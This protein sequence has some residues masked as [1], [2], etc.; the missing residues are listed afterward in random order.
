MMNEIRDFGACLYSLGPKLFA[1]PVGNP[2]TPPP[3]D[4]YRMYCSSCGGSRR[5]RVEPVFWAAGRQICQHDAH[6]EYYYWSARDNVVI[7]HPDNLISITPGIFRLR[8]TDCDAESLAVL[9]P[10][11][12]GPNGV[13]LAVLPARWAG[14]ATPNTPAAV[15]Y[16]LD[17]AARCI[18]VDA[19]SAAIAMFRSALEQFL[20]EQNFRE[21]MLGPKIDELECAIREKQAP[22]WVGRMDPSVLT[23]SLR[24]MKEL[25]NTAVHEALANPDG[26][27]VHDA[28]LLATIQVAILAILDAAYEAPKR[29]ER[30]LAVLASNTCKTAAELRLPI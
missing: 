14:I 29:M 30:Q 26:A 2:S 8:C 18:S 22:D 23:A 7:Q 11:S 9:Y 10:R 19:T 20:T 1:A 16:F 24:A 27:R 4:R 12:D 15:S 21:R 25:A 28:N 6:R 3:E 13:G 5:M 17:Q